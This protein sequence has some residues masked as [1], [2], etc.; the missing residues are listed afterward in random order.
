[1][2]D[3]KP[4]L[5]KICVNPHTPSP[6]GAVEFNSVNS[7]PSLLR[8]TRIKSIF[9]PPVPV[10]ANPHGRLTNG[11]L[12]QSFRTVQE[13]Y[14]DDLELKGREDAFKKSHKQFID[15]VMLDMEDKK[16]QSLDRRTKHWNDGKSELGFSNQFNT[17]SMHES[18]HKGSEAYTMSE[19]EKTDNSVVSKTSLKSN[20]S[21]NPDNAHKIKPYNRMSLFNTLMET[22]GAPEMNRKR[23]GTIKI[24]P[25]T[26]TTAQ[27]RS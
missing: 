13:I 3:R 17:T 24:P 4:Y 12:D 5:D 7:F 6:E 18:S 26:P 21:Y 9:E 15:L 11:F 8:Y 14:R 22:E 16:K 2:E 10:V 25:K 23:Y 20:S 1:M 27:S 19:F